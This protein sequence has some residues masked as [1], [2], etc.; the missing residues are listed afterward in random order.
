MSYSI[1][2]TLNCIYNL[3]AYRIRTCTI[4]LATNFILTLGIYGI[5]PYAYSRHCNLL[6]I[7]CI[8]MESGSTT[9]PFTANCIPAFFISMIHTCIYGCTNCNLDRKISACFMFI[10]S[11]RNTMPLHVNCRFR[12]YPT[13]FTANSVP[14]LFVLSCVY[15]TKRR[16]WTKLPEDHVQLSF[17]C[18]ALSKCLVN[19]ELGLERVRAT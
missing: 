4:L 11:C 13:H 3:F 16:E 7:L 19:V 5:R 15:F 8:Y 6:L 18:G 12:N 2:Y 10:D 9:T 17:T 1:L 14:I